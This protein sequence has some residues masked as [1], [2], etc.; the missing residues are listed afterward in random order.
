MTP[1]IISNINSSLDE[2]GN[3]ERDFTLL[4][5]F[6]DLPEDFQKKVKE[7]IEQGH[8]NDDEWNGV[9]IDNIFEP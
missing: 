3:G 6:D 9:S 8:V 4:D 2:S 5:G 1:K 7:A